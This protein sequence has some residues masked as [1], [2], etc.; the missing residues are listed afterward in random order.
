MWEKSND[1]ETAL[2][3]HRNFAGLKKILEIIKSDTLHLLHWHTPSE[4][5]NLAKELGIN[6]RFW[7]IEN[8]DVFNSMLNFL[9]TCD[10]DWDL[11]ILK[12]IVTNN[13]IWFTEFMKEMSNP[14]KKL[15]YIIL[16]IVISKLQ[17]MQ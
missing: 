15:K 9:R 5:I 3:L 7:G 14:F 12:W 8:I 4:T 1:I 6:I 10:L 13:V 16:H 17:K 11:S 2:V